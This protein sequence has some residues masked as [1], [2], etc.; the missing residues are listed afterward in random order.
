MSEKKKTCPKRLVLL[1]F[2]EHVKRKKNVEKS[3]L[4]QLQHVDDR[5]PKPFPV[6][7]LVD[8]NETLNTDICR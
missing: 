1:E 6:K 5:L 7:G 8:P 2:L 3:S 4:T